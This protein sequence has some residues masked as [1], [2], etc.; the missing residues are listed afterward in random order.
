MLVPFDLPPGFYANGTETQAAGRW[1][2]GNLVRWRDKA[3][4]PVGGWRQ[5]RV[6]SLT[7]TP[8]AVLA[9]SDLSSDKRFAV[10][11]ADSLTVVAANG[12]M[13]VATPAGL[14][15]GRV[16]A[17]AN[18]GYG[19]GFYGA[20]TYGTPR[21][22][23]ATILDADTWTFDTW[24]QNLIACSTADGRIFEWKPGDTAATVVANAPVNNRAIMVT[25]ER[26]L[27]ALAASGNPRLVKWSDREA[28]T[29]WAAAATNEAGDMELQSAGRIMCGLK[30]RGQTLIL[31]DEDAWTATYQGPPYV[32]GF[33]QVGSGCGI[34]SRHGA[35]STDAGV[36]WM[37]EDGFF[38]YAGQSV[39]RMQCDVAD[40][41]FSGLNAAQ[42]SKISVV[43]IPVE[44]EVWWFYPTGME[45]GAYV[46][47]NYVTGWWAT[48]EL[49]RT[50]GTTGDVFDNPI[51]VSPQGIAYDH[52]WGFDHR[53]ATPWAETGPL[54]LGNGDQAMSVIRLVP[55]GGAPDSV[56][57]S[58]NGRMYPND[59]G[60]G[61]GPYSISNPVSLRLTARQMTLRIDG[62][63]NTDWRVGPF[64]IEAR[65][66]GQR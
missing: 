48:G 20:G 22:Y 45:C 11:A 62:A 25:A 49:A 16:D 51:W 52:E 12:T 5:R 13:T 19:G 60:Y 34:V 47:F 38:A 31:T 32:Y 46:S 56:T 7:T 58:V 3:L 8:R 6:L 9:W 36:F 44:G 15:G 54:Q 24:G 23:S 42:R 66:R 21:A 39:Q 61:V 17:S 27:F 14:A 63:T 53:E 37:G 41:V 30:T 40:R 2:D 33:Q 64:R 55:D 28:N 26:F 50:A 18:Q 10:G 65:A 35:I 1:H 57:A 29:V 43:H 4:S 59:F